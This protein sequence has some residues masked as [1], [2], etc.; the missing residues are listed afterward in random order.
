MAKALNR[1]GMKRALVVHSEGL[2]EMSPL[3]PG[4][5]LDVTPDR[6]DKFSFDPLEF[7]IPRCNIENLKGGGPEYNAEVL[8]RVLGGE[9]GPI[10]DALILNAAAALLVS[11]RVRNLAEGVSVARETQQSGKSLKT[12][13][14]WKDISNV[15]YVGYCNY[16]FNCKLVLANFLLPLLLLQ[17]FKDDVGMDA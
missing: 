15:S 2:D 10:A 4:L 1:F 3:G 9:R 5:V 8:K 12:L 17:K 7:G 11:G 13:N 14:Q 16:S 6:I